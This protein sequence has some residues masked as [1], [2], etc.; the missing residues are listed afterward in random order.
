MLSSARFSKMDLR[1]ARRST[2]RTGYRCEKSAVG[3]GRRGQ[4]QSLRCSSWRNV[5]QGDCKGTSLVPLGNERPLPKPLQEK[6]EKRCGKVFP[7]NGQIGC[8]YHTENSLC[9]KPGNRNE[10]RSGYVGPGTSA[11]RN[12]VALSRRTLNLAR[13]GSTGVTSKRGTRHMCKEAPTLEEG[14]EP[15]NLGSLVWNEKASGSA[16]VQIRRRSN[17]SSLSRLTSGPY[18]KG[19][20]KDQTPSTKH[21]QKL[22][23]ASVGSTTGGRSDHTLK[24]ETRPL[25]KVKGKRS[26]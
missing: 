22:E 3:M 13:K 11:P 10:G 16:N 21:C 24:I 14:N 6:E 2:Y 15:G 18:T 19:C 23:T 4:W 8:G 5:Q 17:R 25:R 12:G 26:Q 1:P 9:L 7:C 20:S